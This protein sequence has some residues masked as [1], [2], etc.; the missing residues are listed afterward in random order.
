M[1]SALAGLKMTIG[2]LGQPNTGKSTLFNR[3]TG[4]RQHVG[5]WPGK[6]VEQKSGEFRSNDITYHLVD[7]PGTY[8]L[9]ANS[10]EEL[11]TRDF[12]FSGQSD[13]IVVVIDASQMERSLYLLADYAGIN[14]PVV[15][16]LNMM[17]VA[18]QNGKKI[19]C[20]QIAK[21]LKIPVVPMVATKKTGTAELLDGLKTAAVN[22]GVIVTQAMLKEYRTAFGATFDA[23]LNLLPEGGIGNYSAMWLGGKLLEGDQQIMKLVRDTVDREQWV[24]I[25]AL[26]NQNPDGALR[27]SNCKYEW[28]K[29]II[30][31]NVYD[32]AKGS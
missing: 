1:E 26:I 28:V 21:K 6:T 13:A 32:L 24:Q 30:A 10:E 5:N 16:V 31:G 4:A 11:I 12:I 2:L 22:Q 17:D 29:R 7:L 19:D 18:H 14:L 25:E 23:L 3:L 8:S 27:A 9:A 15:V 20:P